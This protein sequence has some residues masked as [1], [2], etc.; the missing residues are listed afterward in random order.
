MRSIKRGPPKD[1]KSG[2]RRERSWDYDKAGDVQCI[3]PEWHNQAGLV[4]QDDRMLG[5]CGNQSL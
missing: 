2:W 3:T 5:N 1:S 4:P